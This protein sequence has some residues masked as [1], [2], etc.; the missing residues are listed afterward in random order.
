VNTH[1]FLSLEDACDKLDCWR[2]HYNEERPHSAIGKIPLITLANPTEA[3]SPPDQGKAENSRPQRSKVGWQCTN[4]W[5]L[6]MTAEPAEGR[7][8]W[9]HYT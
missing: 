7:S 2:R 5:S 8:H 9:V 4:R 1:W 3:T 6:V